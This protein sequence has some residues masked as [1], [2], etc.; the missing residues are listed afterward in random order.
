MKSAETWVKELD[1][2]SHP[3]GGYYRQT[4][5]SSHIIKSHTN[6]DVPLYTNILFLLED[7]NPS[8]FHKLYSN[9]VWYYHDG[10]SFTVHCIYPDGRYELVVLGKNV[11]KGE[12][13]QF[14]V[15]AGVIFGS[16][17]VEGYGLVSCMVSPGFDF[18]EFKLYERQELLD[19]FPQH[20]EIITKLTRT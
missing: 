1:L 9:E 3:E 11:S 8:N 17:V 15:P 14:E 13:L 2:Q 19:L 5:A 10:E 20:S 18:R 4:G 16:S 12:K 6:L 7:K